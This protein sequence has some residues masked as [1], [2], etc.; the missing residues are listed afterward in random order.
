MPL[1]NNP[2]VVGL[3]KQQN[4]F[5]L[6]V[7]IRPTELQ[8]IPEQ[9][10]GVERSLAIYLVNTENG[11]EQTSLLPIDK[12]KVQE[13]NNWPSVSGA[14]VAIDPLR[15]RLRLGSE[16]NPQFTRL[17]VSYYYGFSTTLGGGHYDKGSALVHAEAP[18][19]WHKGVLAEVQQFGLAKT[20][21]YLAEN[22]DKLLIINLDDDSTLVDNIGGTLLVDNTVI[23]ELV[24]QAGNGARPCWRLLQGLT[25]AVSDPSRRLTLRLTGLLLEGSLTLQGNLEVYISHCTFM[26]GIEPSLLGSELSTQTS[27]NIEH[28]I[29]GA[30]C[31]S[32]SMAE[33]QI[34]DSLVDALDKSMA[35]SGV[36]DGTYAP[37]TTLE[38]VTV[39]GGVRALKLVSVA[40]SI[41]TGS[42]K[43]ARAETGSVR[44][45][46]LPLT[47]ETYTP[48]RYRC[49]PEQT[50]TPLVFTS[51]VYGQPGYGQ[52]SVKTSLAIRNGAENG[53]EM[54]CFQGV[55]HS[56]REKS[57]RQVLDE[58]LPFNLKP[59]IFYRN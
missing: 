33:L 40:N 52:L 17:E 35:L 34:H 42:V 41:I 31:L 47:A 49:Q 44:Y 8:A 29:I 13:L 25:L 28:S 15:G 1:F 4:E 56:E 20:I 26:P 54:G 51:T 38:R 57:L 30:L 48:Q 21:G 3:V 53:A 19:L 10:Y 14:I 32:Q 2:I 23:Q 39:L 37:S 43:A 58:Y 24:I 59:Q 46:Y 27:I 45:S 9:Y 50:N 55:R 36:E 7:P 11:V 18:V 22:S 16:L 6:P 5:N 12:L